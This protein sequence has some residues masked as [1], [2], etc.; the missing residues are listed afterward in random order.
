[1]WQCLYGLLFYLF[2]VVYLKNKARIYGQKRLTS[3]QAKVVFAI[4]SLFS[5]YGLCFGDYWGY[6]ALVHQAYETY[7]G[8]SGDKWYL[9]L[10]MEPIYNMLSVICYGNYSLWRFVIFGGE[11]LCLIYLL[12]SSKILNYETLYVFALFCLY[13]I[14]AGRVSWGIVCFWMGLY[15]YIQTLQKKYLLFVAAAIIS[16]YSLLLL[17]ALIP[18]MFVPINRK[19]AL[20]LLFIVPSL[21]VFFGSFLDEFQSQLLGY[22]DSSTVL[23]FSTKLKDYQDLDSFKLWGSSVGETIHFSLSRFPLYYVMFLLMYYRFSGKICFSRLQSRLFNITFFLFLYTCI[24]LFARIGSASFYDRYL[25]MMY[26]PVFLLTYGL[27]RDF[28]MRRRDF[29]FCLKLMC[30]SFVALYIK[31]V[32]YYSFEDPTYRL[33]EK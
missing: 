10:H 4:L 11:F 18:F 20:I 8:F 32:Y 24:V 33:F 19:I 5:V 21:S 2:I 29:R 17:F 1:M 31:A 9:Y 23:V 15:T 27:N 14:C 13:S 28:F 16:H 25:M 3:S 26:L 6:G 30:I 12:K 7:M 22:D